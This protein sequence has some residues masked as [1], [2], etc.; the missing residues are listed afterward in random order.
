M[1]D[2][3]AAHTY[4]HFISQLLEQSLR[5][6]K[7]EE[8]IPILNRII[9]LL[10]ATDG[11]EYLER[12]R[13]LSEKKNLLIEVAKIDST[14][15]RPCTPLATSSLLTGQGDDPPLEHELRMEMESADRVDMLVSFIKWS[16]LRLLIPAFEKLN[17]RNIP[18]RIISTSY[19]GASD[20]EAL[21]WLARQHNIHIKISYDT[22]GTRLHAKSYHFM[23]KS[24]YSTAYVGSANM[25]H[26]AMTNGLEWTVKVT[27][28]DMPHIIQRFEAEFSTYWES[29]DF[30]DYRDKDFERFRLAIDRHRQRDDIGQR[31]FAEITARPFQ[32]RILEALAAARQ[33]GKYRNLV[34]AATGTGKTVVSALD[35]QQMVGEHGRKDSLLFVAHRKEILEQARQCF[36]AVLHDPNF[37]ELLV[38]GHE[39]RE[40][41]H[42]FASIQSL[43]RRKPWEALGREHFYYV[44]VDEAHHIAATSYRE[45]AENLDPGILLGLTAT[46]ERMDGTSILTDFDGEFAAEIRLPEALEE[47]LLCPFHYF[48]VTDT[49]D[50]S[51]DRFWRNGKYDQVELEN[52]L[53]IESLVA[54][55]RVD[56]IIKALN[57]YQP[58]LDGIRGVGFC[59]GVRHTRFMAECFNRAGIQSN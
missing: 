28:Q 18:V 6:V 8:R 15:S 14:S 58:N 31:F 13:L 59:V 3:A 49:I 12:K 36:Q 50:L 44:I 38:D 34:V 47:R 52:V 7:V 23:R 42:V 30:E 5:I 26:S 54:N 57:R 55:Q 10:S 22:G 35:Y 56:N 43:C 53:A 46:P 2:E 20:P 25:S 11:L 45:V 4:S 33:Q 1:D 16:G 41:R 32:Q 21:E 24:G 39:P 27:A 29:D 37:G 9:D 40:W 17:A 19:M 48:G 51:E